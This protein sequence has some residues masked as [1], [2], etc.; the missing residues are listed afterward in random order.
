[1]RGNVVCSLHIT[2]SSELEE[3]WEAALRVCVKEKSKGLPQ[4]E[5]A[6]LIWSWQALSQGEPCTSRRCDPSLHSTHSQI[7]V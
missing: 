7:T 2:V 1:M 6:R 4:Q 5:R 3:E